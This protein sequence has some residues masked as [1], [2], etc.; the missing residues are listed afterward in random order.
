MA[1]STVPLPANI[2]AT[3]SLL[4]SL[5]S[6]QTPPQLPLPLNPAVLQAM[7]GST[8]SLLQVTSHDMS[9]DVSCDTS[10]TLSP[11]TQQASQTVNLLQAARATELLRQQVAAQQASLAVQ[12][13]QLQLLQQQKMLK[14]DE[15]EATG[16]G[17]GE[18]GMKSEK[19]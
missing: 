18:G 4:H 17:S 15:G 13:Q 6:V 9:H 7:T 8:S 16:Q 10:H 14:E 12:Q 11:P 19:S 5:T 2:Q 1:S 3:A